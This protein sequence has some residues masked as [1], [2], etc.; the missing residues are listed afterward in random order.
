MLNTIKTGL[1]SFG[2]SG[3]IFHAPF[4]NA[5]QGFEL[6]AVTERSKK[7][8]AQYYP[9]IKSYDSVEALLKDPAIELVIVNTPNATHYDFALQALRQGKHVLVEKAFTTTSGEAQQ[10][11]REAGNRN[12]HVL[13]YQNR[14]YDGDFLSV[15]KV[16]E[17]GRLGQLVEVHFHFDR[18]RYTI[19]PKAK[20]KPG[21]GSG[22]LYDLGP[23]VTDAV[24]SLFGP[25]ER[26]TKTLGHFRPNTKVDDYAHIHMSYSDGM[27]VF[28][29]ASMLVADIQP[30]FIV[31]GTK[32]SYIKQRVNVQEDQ[33]LQEMSLDNPEYGIESEETAGIL[34]TVNEDGSKTR[35]TIV[36]EKA[37]YLNVFN[38][39]YETIRNGKPYPV[40]EAQIVKQL[41]ILE[42]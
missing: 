7:T 14:R 15:K 16:I 12:L 35:E 38:D 19:G 2:M 9:G 36:A 8:A 24:L 41:E 20:E 3:K 6:C 26:W 30:G 11:F 23:H 39:V 34:T 40:T 13:P 31:H 10:L 4:L 33:L 42:G 22:I 29:S 25:P 1:L 28:V 32:G 18:Y 21:P 37:S 5:H 17:S 27:Q